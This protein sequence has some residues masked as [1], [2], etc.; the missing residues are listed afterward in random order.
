MPTTSRNHLTNRIISRATVVALFAFFTQRPLYAET[1]ANHAE[2][3]PPGHHLT[4][5]APTIT[6]ASGLMRI[7]TA[8]EGRP[9]TFRLA[10][11]GE[12]FSS[13]DF[14]V[15]GDTHT[16]FTGTLALSYLPWRFLEFFA[17]LRSQSNENE[18]VDPTR[19]DDGVILALGDLGLGAKFQRAIHPAITIG[20]NVNVLMLNSVGGVSFDLDATSVYAG[21]I[22][23]FD[24][25]RWIG[26]PLLAHANVGYFVDNSD[27]LADFVGYPL[28]SLQVEK[29]SLGMNKSRFQF[30]A[31]LEAPLRQF[32]GIGLTPLFEF[33]LDY[34]TGD[35]DAD[36]TN[37][38]F[39][40]PAG[41]L[42][43]DE[44]DGRFTAWL[45]LGVRVNPIAGLFAD[46]A[47]DIGLQS[48]GFGY[49]P[50][51]VPWN[52]IF[53]VGYAVDPN[54]PPRPATSTAEP[55]KPEPLEGFIRGQ[56]IEA[57]TNRPLGDAVIL[58][59]DNALTPQKALADGTFLSYALPPGDVLIT[60]DHPEFAT[61]TVKVEIKAG[62]THDLRV[63]LD[64]KTPTVVTGQ[65]RC[66][67]V[68]AD[69]EAITAR[70]LVTGPEE[71]L[72]TTN[73]EGNG[74]LDLKPGTY[75]V[76]A[77]AELFLTKRRT[78]RLDLKETTNLVFVL[79]PKPKRSG[80]KVTETGLVLQRKIHFATGTADLKDNAR[81]LLD[82]VA[83]VM[84]SEAKDQRFE[85]QGHTD[86]TGS[87]ARNL[88]LSLERAE[89]VRNYLIGSGVEPDRTTAKG[90]GPDR[91]K[92]PNISARNR[93]KNRRVEFRRIP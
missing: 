81:E 85:I 36:F 66:R 28:A 37:P 76:E 53:G 80:V 42:T 51:V 27:N 3:S 25:G 20:A 60:V 1:P 44:L 88:A 72:L 21:G 40:Q 71:R 41:P 89:S 45:T 92:V 12:F 52:L 48:P 68:T 93:A 4:D 50:P 62:E 56:V 17:T 90:Y 55:T 23:S 73:E 63:A 84:L 6:G 59:A 34:A 74:V 19:V 43:P 87:R 29:F 79:T 75:V 5:L 82:E 46:I 15:A 14:L 64:A 13:S 49:G 58:Y 47:A 8:R 77:Q 54:P 65:L 69:G 78:V 16:R 7:V 9:H 32:V 57:G 35:A 18:R 33:A 22:G 2:P 24:L 86:S 30:K 31:G 91:P 38:A 83:H 11:R 61:R 39:F 10:L 26:F 70:L 67:V